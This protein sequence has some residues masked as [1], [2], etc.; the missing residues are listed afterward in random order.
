[1]N[2]LN[3]YKGVIMFNQ[4]T[5]EVDESEPQLQAALVVNAPLSSDINLSIEAIN[6]TATGSYRYIYYFYGSSM[7]LHRR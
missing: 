2:L 1:M 6:I 4:S 5:Y 3:N 7:I